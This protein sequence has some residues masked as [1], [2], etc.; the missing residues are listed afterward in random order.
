MIVLPLQYEKHSGPDA[1]GQH[2]I[3]FT[4]D[5]SVNHG[6]FNPLSI[7][8]GTQ[9]LVMLIEA[10]EITEFQSESPDDTI[11]RFR[12]Q[13]HA[14][15]GEIAELNKTTAEEEKDKLKKTLVTNGM[16]KKSTKE[17]DINQLA[18]VIIK[19][20]KYKNGIKP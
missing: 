19:L 5:E 13:M 9:F 6:E 2:R 1:T 17:L 11:E 15:L 10:P 4:M 12:K 7:K 16:I 8:Q 20:K 14:I 18:T 3:V